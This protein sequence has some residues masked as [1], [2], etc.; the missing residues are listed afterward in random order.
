MDK[1]SLDEA[2]EGYQE[3]TTDLEKLRE[4]LR[5]LETET[6]STLSLLPAAVLPC[7]TE[8]ETREAAR[9]FY[10]NCPKIT[11]QAIKDALRWPD[12][13]YRSLPEYVGP[14]NL[15]TTCCDCNGRAWVEFSSR[16]DL[17][18][19][20]K[21]RLSRS[22]CGFCRAVERAKLEQA[23]TEAETEKAQIQ[24][25]Q[26]QQASSRWK[27]ET[28]YMTF[29]EANAMPYSEYL[30]TQ[31]WQNVRKR[32]LRRA[33]YKCQLCNRDGTLH[34]HHKTYETLGCE[35]NDDVIVLCEECHARHHSK[36]TA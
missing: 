2:I 21:W 30:E 8:E 13:P 17:Q 15:E 20:K 9:H 6:K 18:T 31:H 19:H 4:S 5:Q 26:K 32:A 28:G 24:E 36:E 33:K 11:S 34:T 14:F 12:K 1:M 27:T 35:Q 23:I 22:Q 3:L 16:T 29:E 25:S 10:W 7:I